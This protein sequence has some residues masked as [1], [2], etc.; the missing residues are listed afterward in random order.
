MVF[1]TEPYCAPTLILTNACQP[2][3]SF[4]S[5]HLG[6]HDSYGIAYHILSPSILILNA[7]FRVIVTRY[8][9]NSRQ[10]F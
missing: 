9:P 7:I 4:H 8:G 2:R 6:G 10:G 1:L 3:S 5:L